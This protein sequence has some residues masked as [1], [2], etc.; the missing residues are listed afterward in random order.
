[1]KIILSQ[2]VA[3]FDQHETFSGS[4]EN[5][6]NFCYFWVFIKEKNNLGFELFSGPT[7]SVWPASE[8]KDFEDLQK[9][10]E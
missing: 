3:C 1:M 9:R 10:F 2:Y 5:V 7:S 4:T 8:Q 6:C